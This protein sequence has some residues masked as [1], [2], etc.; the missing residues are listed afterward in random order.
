MNYI[1]QCENNN[2]TAEKSWFY[3]HVFNTEFNICFHKS[4]KDQCDTC[5]KFVNYNK[6]EKSLHQEGHDMHIE[7]KN[8]ARQIKN[9][10]KEEAKLEFCHLLEFD[11][12][13]V[14]CYPKSGS[15][16]IFHKRRLA[17]YNSTIFNV[18]IYLKSN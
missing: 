3:H 11:L 4:R 9:D 2:S 16:A 6:L 14:R 8:I 1:N 5:F 12:E 15:K 10:L 17:V 18:I 13:A 7:R